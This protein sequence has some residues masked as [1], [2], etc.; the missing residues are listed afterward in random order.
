MQASLFKIN[1]A[2]DPERLAA[3]FRAERR[4]H[5][6]HFLE[7]D[8]A[9]QLLEHVRTSQAWRLVL[10]SGD[11]VI[12]LDRS[13]QDSLGQE[14]TQQLDLAVYAAAREGFQYRYETIRVPDREAERK[15]SGTVLDAFARFMSEDT[16]LQFF[17]TVLD[18]PE[19]GFADAQ[20]TAY[21]PGHFLTAH[22][23]KVAGKNRKAAYVMN[24]SKSWS[25]D[26]GG[27]LAF[28][29]PGQA[30]VKALVPVF[31]SLNLFAVPQVHS[32]TMV[33]PYAPRRRYSVT[34]WLRTNAAKPD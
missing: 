6:P 21:S 23:D 25:A 10:N 11:K 20:A 5:V 31:N 19:I 34:G 7:P 15:A 32:V 14:R 30:E 16:S 28:H 27:L 8:G 13:T 26:W 9:E 3:V 22:D 33:A 24:L 4:L 1:G 17:R 2:H 29:N 12:E 18:D